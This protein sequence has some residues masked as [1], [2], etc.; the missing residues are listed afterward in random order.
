MAET[1]KEQN[2]EQARDEELVLMAQNGD[3]AAQEYLLDKYKSSS[4]QTARISSRKG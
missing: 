3:D 4:A 2:Y 1:T